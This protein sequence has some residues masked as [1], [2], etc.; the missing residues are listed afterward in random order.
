MTLVFDTIVVAA[1]ERVSSES[2]LCLPFPA[3]M[4]T[5]GTVTPACALR[6]VRSTA[7]DDACLLTALGGAILTFDLSTVLASD[8]AVGATASA[9]NSLSGE[10]G[11][12]PPA[13]IGDRD[14]AS[15]G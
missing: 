4:I 11:R 7:A 14:A 2:S 9:D 12:A 6:F 1:L 3:S 10:T 8:E 5:M 15:G 13:F